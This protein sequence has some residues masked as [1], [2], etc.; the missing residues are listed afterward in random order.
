MV[1][2]LYK[3][4]FTEIKFNDGRKVKHRVLL[5]DSLNIANENS[6]VF[7]S[8]YKKVVVEALDKFLPKISNY[9]KE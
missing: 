4:E 6:E 9:D 2:R 5:L 3:N 8:E 1:R 7:L